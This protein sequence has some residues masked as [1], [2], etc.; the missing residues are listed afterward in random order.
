MK[1]RQNYVSPESEIIELS[2]QGCIASSPLSAPG[3]DDGG[4]IEFN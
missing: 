2:L 3:F 4:E 1:E